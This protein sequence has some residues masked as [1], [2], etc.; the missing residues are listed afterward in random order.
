MI[1][2][3][4]LTYIEIE[5]KPR[6]ELKIGK[7]KVQLRLFNFIDYVRFNSTGRAYFKLLQE[8]QED[9]KTCITYAKLVNWLIKL[10]K[11]YNWFVNATKLR[12]YLMNDVE[13]TV[14]LY[15]HIDE[16][17]TLIKKKT[18]VIVQGLLASTAGELLSS[19]SEKPVGLN[20]R[21][22]GPRFSDCFTGLST[23]LK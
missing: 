14:D 22:I 11:K 10:V 4:P 12:K 3:R 5:L 20:G 23:K 15:S 18:E 13:A 21:S 6:I 9:Y 19:A 8:E 17:N 2:M 16:Y 7:I 1:K